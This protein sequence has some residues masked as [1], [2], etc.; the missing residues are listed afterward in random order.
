[1]LS[2]HNI[3]DLLKCRSEI[4]IFQVRN[5]EGRLQ[6]GGRL[7]QFPSC[8]VIVSTI[9]IVVGDEVAWIR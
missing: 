7:P 5:S 4:L 6:E 3:S 1:M 8:A 2:Q 9:V